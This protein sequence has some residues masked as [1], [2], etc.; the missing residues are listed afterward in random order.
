[1]VELNIIHIYDAKFYLLTDSD[2]FQFADWKGSTLLE[3]IMKH[4][5]DLIFG[6]HI[7]LTLNF[8]H[9]F[10]IFNHFCSIPISHLL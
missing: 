3:I 8:V 1:M 6:I 7:I 9:L 2:I 5:Y 4:C 10:I